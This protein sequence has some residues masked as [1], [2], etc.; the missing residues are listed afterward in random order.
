M[1]G[2]TILICA[3][4]GHNDGPAPEST[5]AGD[6]RIAH[7]PPLDLTKSGA[8]DN[9][10]QRIELAIKNVRDRQLLTAHGFW[11][12]FHGILGLG[13]KTD[14]FDPDNGKPVNAI[15][16]ICSGTKKVHG[17]EFIPTAH[18]LDV[19]TASTPELLF[20]GQGHQDQFIAE[21]TQWGMKPDRKFKVQ[22]RD[23]T[24][25]DFVNNSKMRASLK[26]G[27]ELSWTILVLGQ[28]LDTNI[29]WTNQDGDKLTFDD[30]LR[31]ELDA[32]MDK[33]ACGGTHRLFD[34]SWVHHLHLQRG[35]KTE[36]IWKKVAANTTHHQELAKKWQNADGSFSSDFFRGP[37]RSSEPQLRINTTGHTFEWLA[38]SLPD[39]RLRE[40]WVQL[41][42]D[43]LALMIL[44]IQRQKMEGGT[45]Y[46]AVHGLIIYHARVYDRS[47][48]KGDLAMLP[49]PPE[50]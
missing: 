26:E 13:P 15:D 8:S 3:A 36:G 42:A 22:G 38:L 5:G 46:H 19:L 16:Y 50:Q 47:A 34:L 32:S 2:G 35:G 44:D 40:P 9:L 17:M 43:R 33:A 11:T 1:V 41:A 18:G 45:L 7:Y 48:L 4:C 29:S 24:F 21:M 49:L 30:L 20:V 28:Y 39:S 23:Y 25:M 31:Y 14:L 6:L 37:G 27:Q 10:R 12:I